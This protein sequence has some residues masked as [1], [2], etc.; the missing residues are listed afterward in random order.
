MFT[1]IH[2]MLQVDEL[3]GKNWGIDVAKG[4]YAY[5]R[6]IKDAIRMAKRKIMSK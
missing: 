4:M 2:E 1:L 3:Y 5:P 6:S